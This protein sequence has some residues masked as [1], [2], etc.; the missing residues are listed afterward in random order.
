VK[1][2]R[3]SVYVYISLLFAGICILGVAEYVATREGA[4]GAVLCFLPGGI[5]IGL[6]AG[7]WYREEAKKRH[8]QKLDKLGAFH[9]QALDTLTVAKIGELERLQLKSWLKAMRKPPW[10]DKIPEVEV[11]AKFVFP[12]LRYLGYED[13]DMTMRVPI[14]MQE[15]SSKV[16][17]EADW[18]IWDRDGNA[19]II[20]EAKAPSVLLSEAVAKQARSYAFR[21]GAPIYITTN[22]KEIQ[23]FHRG[24][25]EDRCVLSCTTSQLSKNWEAIQEAASKSNVIALRNKLTGKE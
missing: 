3:S 2:S 20:V 13:N 18:V 21:L 5:S 10:K 4:P 9:Q 23:I 7:L 22:G 17:G 19:L 1:S 12:L 25:I 15:G 11:E 8:Q 14:P 16:T 6:G 24:I